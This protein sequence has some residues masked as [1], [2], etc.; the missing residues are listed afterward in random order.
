[1]ERQRPGNESIDDGIHAPLA[2]RRAACN[3]MAGRTIDIV[4]FQRFLKSVFLVSFHT[5]RKMAMIRGIEIIALQH[6]I[7]D[8]AKV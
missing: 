3:R 4:T 6:T 5:Y 8:L 7:D 2:I 1:L